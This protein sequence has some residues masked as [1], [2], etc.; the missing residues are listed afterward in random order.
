M[1]KPGSFIN[2]ENQISSDKR[3]L[4]DEKI[5]NAETVTSLTQSGEL[6]ADFGKLYK[7]GL[8]S[9]SEI[10]SNTSEVINYILLNEY[11]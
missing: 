5:L 11:P 1:L 7:S 4:Q 2:N 8:H 6:L 10:E 3:G 9:G